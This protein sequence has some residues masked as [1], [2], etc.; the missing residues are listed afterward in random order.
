[1]RRGAVLALCLGLAISG[2]APAATDPEEA[3][4]LE[5]ARLWQSR[6]RDDL[7]REFLDRL[8][9][10][11]PEH[12]EGLLLLARQQARANQDAAVAATYER[13]RAAHP[14]HPAVARLAALLRIR[15]ADR[16]RLRLARQLA[17]AGRTQEALAAF[18]AL[19]PDV[20]P[21]D[22]LALEYAQLL[23]SSRDG[24]EKAG[25]LIEELAAR[26]PEDPRFRLALARSRSLAR[27]G[28]PEALAALREL[29]ADP[30]VGRQAR[31]AWRRAVLALEAV[32]ESLPAL[33]EYAASEPGD[34]AVAERLAAVAKAVEAKQAAFADPALAARREGLALLEEG[35]LEAAE[36][37]LGEAIARRPGDAEAIGALGLL[38]MR[39]GRHGEALPH[40]AK[41]RELDADGRGKWDGLLRTAR[42]WDLLETA[43]KA[44]R[45]GELESASRSLEEARSLD[46]RE[47]NA[48]IDLARVRLAQGREEEAEALFREARDLAPA[49]RGEIARALDALRAGRLRGEAARLAAAGRNEEAIAA[50]ERAA[51]LDRDDPWLRL[52]LARLYAATGRAA[53]GPALF[54]DLLARRPG[55]ADTSFA[56]ALFLSGVDR[57]PEALAALE[58]ADPASR[59]AAMTRLQH[60]LWAS[61][62]G[63]RAAALAQ[64][65]DGEAAAR[66]LASARE[67]VGEDADFALEVAGAHAAAGDF[68]GAR[69][70]LARFAAGPAQDA[71]PWRLGQARLLDRMD[72]DAPLREALDRIAALGPGTKAQDGEIADLELSLAIRRADALRVAGDPAR[73]LRLLGEAR[74][75]RPTREQASRLARAEIRAMR[76]L[77]RWE[78]AAAAYRALLLAEAGPADARLGLVEVLVA[79]GRRDEAR[80]EIASLPGARAKDDPDFAASLAASLLA[81]GDFAAAAARVDEALRN[82][83]DHPWLLDLAGQLARRE[84]RIDRAIAY[85]R[86]SLAAAFS[87]ATPGERGRLSTLGPPAAPGGPPSIDAAPPGSVATGPGGYRA[88]AELLDRETGWFS[89]ALDW[90]SRSGSRGKSRLDA[91]ELPL[92]RRTGWTGSGRWFIRADAARVSAGKIDLADTGESSTFGSLLLCDPPCA[93]ERGQEAKGLAFSAGYERD[94]LRIDLGTTPVGFPVVNLVGGAAFRGDLG[95]LSWSVDASR[96]PVEASLLSYAG[97]RDPR[98]GR[99]WGGVVATGVRLGLSRDS[100]GEYGAWSSLDLHRLDGRHVQANERAQ[101]MGGVYRRFVDEDGRLLTAGL[102]GMWWRYRENAGEF[103]LGHGGYYSPRTYGSLSLPL[104]WGIR[105]ER[106]SFVLRASVSVSWSRT[107][108]APFFPEDEALQAQALAQSAVTGIDPFHEGGAGGRSFGRALAAGWEHQLAPRVFVGGRIELERSPDYTPNRFLVYLRV[109]TDH[110][111]ARPVALPPEPILRGAR[112]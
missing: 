47:A 112:F 78:D 59:S 100:G 46:P 79:A 35:R 18:R 19:F 15:G 49:R 110:A 25:A 64:G 85:Q 37:R 44:R 21:D 2:A 5:R 103:T 83:P 77:S 87:R 11:A 8:F 109:A 12:P 107:S 45:A 41:A 111:A 66:I 22:E 74:P 7:A 97:T 67:A 33:R 105:G 88:L 104:T 24:R 61:V 51:A 86:R 31:E 73:A 80:E 23:A 92:E 9:R 50:F 75:A 20:F 81:L 58:R 34:T 40:F 29:S 38:R 56:L 98:T 99:R 28:A 91:Q 102:T 32:A 52:D 54:E 72:A 108:R 48:A 93:G 39:Q 60:R 1:M 4:L 13:L 69:A 96:R 62:Q 82:H 43:G 3:A 6:N 17:R 70:L 106:T 14:G 65:G 30:V 63:R 27:P 42:Y 16:E 55:D 26:H 57:E 101:L 10:I 90:R 89:T 68:D 94:D 76:A 71:L 36:A 84:G 53:R 95:T